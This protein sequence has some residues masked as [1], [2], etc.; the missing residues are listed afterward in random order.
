MA[1]LPEPLSR[2]TFPPWVL[3]VLAGLRARGHAAFV[4]GGAVRDILLGREVKEYDL[5]SDARPEE[6]AAAFPRVVPTGLPHGTVTVVTDG[7]PVEVTTFRGEGAYVDGRRPT[8]VTF[9]D[10]VVDDLA[11]RDLT[12]NAMA[13]DPITGLFVDPFGGERDLAARLVRA[14]GDPAVRFNEDGLRVMRA[15]RVAS[16]LRFRIERGTRRAIPGALPTFRKVAIERVQAELSKLLVG[17]CPGYGIDLLRSTGILAHVIPELLEGYGMWQN[18]WHRYD[19]YHH[20]LRAVDAAEPPTLEIRLA[21]LLHDI[22]KPRTAGPS[23]RGEA[24]EKSFHSH[25]V[26]GAERAKQIC[27]RLRYPLKVVERVALLVREHQ[28]I[29][30]DSWSDAAVRRMLAR[31]GD[32]AFDDLVAVRRADVKGRGRAVEEGLAE[33]DRLV[34][35]VEAERRRRPAL[36]AKDL[37]LH[38]GD[39]MEA[40]GIGPSPEVGEA[41]RYLLDLVIED[42]SRN[43]RETLLAALRERRA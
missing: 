21:A 4:V 22:D 35:R 43:T 14:V 39:V 38:G 24:W 3:H 17:R 12:I 15:V 25:E 40:L 32:D 26:S 5:A 7:H 31:V 41:I 29:Y 34:A 23:P 10:D 42:P 6:V 16:V 28:F 20:V 30:T 1:R 8:E 33:I 37:A 27:L 9:L 13:F 2:A 18:R 36:G 11:R 19:V